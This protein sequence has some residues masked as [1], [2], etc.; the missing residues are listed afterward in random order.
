MLRSVRELIKCKAIDAEGR[1]CGRIKDIYF[2]D[3]SWR[4]AHLILSIEPRQFG[5]KQVLVAPHQLRAIT[6]ADGLIQV[7]L[8]AGQI[9]DLNLAGS[10]LPVCRQ[11][12]SLAYGFPGARIL[13][14][15]TAVSD[16]HLRSAKAVTNYHITASGEFA[17]TLADFIFDD[18][19]WQIRYLGVE[20]SIERK[21]MLFHILP[22]SVERFTWA[23]Q[24]I[25]LRE[26]QPVGL[27]S[28][29]CSAPSFQAA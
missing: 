29:E 3:A 10:V 27:D 7:N 9:E 1:H 2:D 17:G 4:V 8:T 20:Q 13:S 22:Q 6:E 15:G 21:K 18:T 11:Y 5:Q 19:A 26:L 25:L 16:P 14:R 28:A 23:T 24:R 12:A